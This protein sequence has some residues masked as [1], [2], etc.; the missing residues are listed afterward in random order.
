MKNLLSL[1]NS[2]SPTVPARAYAQAVQ[3]LMQPSDKIVLGPS[4]DGGYYLI[5]LNRRHERVFEDI[6]WSTERVFEQTLARAKE[7]GVPVELLPTWYDVDD[8]ASLSRLCHEILD[9]KAET[10][11][12]PAPE[13]RAFLKK[14][15]A[16]K[17][18]L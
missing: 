7:I 9:D 4:D 13:T 6:D 12:F 15:I 10:A 16:S 17:G 3:W 18:P 5:G 1:I 8:R 11:G 14:L 2:D